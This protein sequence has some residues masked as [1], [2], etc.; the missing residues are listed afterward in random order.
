MPARGSWNLPS[1]CRSPAGR[2]CELS[3]AV[4]WGRQHTPTRPSIAARSTEGAIRRNWHPRGRWSAAPESSDPPRIRGCKDRTRQRRAYRFPWVRMPRG[5]R[6]AVLPPRLT[7]SQQQTRPQ[8]ATTAAAV[9]T[10]AMTTPGRQRRRGPVSRCLVPGSS[11][12]DRHGPPASSSAM[13]GRVGRATTRG[14]RMT[15]P[16]A[17]AAS[18]RASTSAI[19]CRHR[20]CHWFQS[21]PH[22]RTNSRA[23]RSDGILRPATADARALFETA[24]RLAIFQKGKSPDHARKARSSHANRSAGPPDGSSGRIGRPIPALILTPTWTFGQLHQPIVQQ[25]VTLDNPHAMKRPGST[26]RISLAARLRY[27]DLCLC[28]LQFSVS[29]R[30]TKLT[31]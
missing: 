16:S 27:S 14:A 28:R 26:C 13:A 10:V 31:E 17:K 20:I 11:A 15:D 1:R 29:W 3:S 25:Q 4:S 24:Q 8:P 19:A 23:T 12:R 22:A 2:G 6:P 7:T 21:P 18:H 9:S 30:C 5:Q